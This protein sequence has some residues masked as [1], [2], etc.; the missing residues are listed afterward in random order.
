MEGV[1]YIPGGATQNVLRAFQVSF[2]KY[3]VF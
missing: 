2:E 1:Q 3:R